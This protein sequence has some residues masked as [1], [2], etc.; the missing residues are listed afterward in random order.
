[1][2]L[3]VDVIVV[4]VVVAVVN[5]DK[6]DSFCALSDNGNGRSENDRRAFSAAN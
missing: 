3:N 1:M 4:V 2:E 6:S 5:D